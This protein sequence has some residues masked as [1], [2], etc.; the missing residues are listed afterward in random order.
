MRVVGASKL[1][2]P[3]FSVMCWWVFGHDWDETP[4]GC[5]VKLV[6]S[7]VHSKVGRAGVGGRQIDGCTTL[8]RV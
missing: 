8:L 2:W 3:V 5:G 7:H 4:A 1:G 6:E